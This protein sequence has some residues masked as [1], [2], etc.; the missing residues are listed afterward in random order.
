MLDM[1]VPVEADGDAVFL[2]RFHRRPSSCC[3]SA[4]HTNASSGSATAA[5]DGTR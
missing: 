4:R 1:V 3:R 5:A 2:L